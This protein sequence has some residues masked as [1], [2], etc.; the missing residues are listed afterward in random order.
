MMMAAMCH[1]NMSDLWFNHDCMN[2][3]E[4]KSPPLQMLTK[5]SLQPL[6]LSIIPSFLYILMYNIGRRTRYC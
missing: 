6:V 3:S 5:S 2:T 1:Y 4:S